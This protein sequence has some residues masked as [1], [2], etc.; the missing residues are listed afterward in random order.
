MLIIDRQST[1]I[2][3][4]TFANPVYLMGHDSGLVF[5]QKEG[6]LFP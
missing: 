5:I 4:W 1:V 3:Y 2:E 6:K